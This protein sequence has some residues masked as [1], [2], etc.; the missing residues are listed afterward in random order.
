MPGFYI[1]NT[2]ADIELN[3]YNEFLCRKDELST[4]DYLIKRNTLDKFFD[5]KLFYEDDD[6]IIITEGVILNKK[7]LIDLYNKSNFIECIKHM[8]SEN[9]DTFYNKFRGSFSGAVY[10]KNECKWII[11]TNQNGDKAI[12]YY[13]DNAKLNFITG[14]QA[15]YVIDAINRLNIQKT[16]NEKAIYYILFYGYMGDDSTYINEIKRLSPGHYLEITKNNFSVHKYHEYKNTE[17]EYS[18]LSEK[19]LIDLFDKKFKE[20]VKLQYDKDLE[21]N[22]RHRAH[23]SAGLDSRMNVWVANKLG[24][25]NVLNTTYCQSGYVDEKIAKEIA[26]DL[27]NELLFKPLD[28]ASYLFDIDKIVSMNYGTGFYSGIAGGQ[29]LL[30]CLNTEVFGLEHSGQMGEVIKG[31]Y[32]SNSDDNDS[33]KIAGYY[34]SKLLDKVP[35]DHLKN[36]KNQEIYGIYVRGFNGTLHTNLIR[37]N[38]TEQVSHLIETDFLEFYLSLPYTYRKN[39]KLYKK[40]IITKYPKAATYIWDI[41]RCKVTASKAQILFK[42]IIYRGSL[43]LFKFFGVSIKNR[44]MAPIDYWLQNNVKLADYFDNY[45]KEHI[46]KFDLSNELKNDIKKLYENGN[47]I[48]KAMVLTVLSALKL[49]T[50]SQA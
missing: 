35:K 1:T 32:Q 19:E 31:D 20:A 47:G 4:S 9:P 11:Y 7:H 44:S 13:Y 18:D 50:K 30:E 15:N 8:I 28:D 46:N 25:K 48:Q 38:Y 43:R 37:Q 10:Y 22:Y 16:I 45:Y 5:D 36:Y 29:R 27:G 26:A 49:Y 3:N 2:N 24:Y 12:F 33:I 6:V 34:S 21:Y 42:R 39:M 23:L 40:W 41:T 17:N 14:S